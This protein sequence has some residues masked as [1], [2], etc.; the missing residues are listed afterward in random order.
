MIHTIIPTAF[1]SDV[2]HQDRIID[3]VRDFILNQNKP[4]ED[5]EEILAPPPPKSA[6]DKGKVEPKAKF[7]IKLP[8]DSLLAGRCNISL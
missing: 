7:E 1:L 6:K 4:P 5:D 8:G 3:S 2:R